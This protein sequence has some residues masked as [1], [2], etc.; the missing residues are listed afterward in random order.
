[1]SATA[2]SFLVL[3]P[4]AAA[5][6]PLARIKKDANGIKLE[7]LQNPVGPFSQGRCDEVLSLTR[8]TEMLHAQQK[9]NC[10]SPEKIT[11]QILMAERYQI[12]FDGARLDCERF[13]QYPREM[14]DTPVTHGLRL[15][16]F[17]HHD[18]VVAELI[19]AA[20]LTPETGTGKEVATILCCNFVE[21][22]RKEA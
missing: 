18:E 11:C 10:F 19:L 7:L 15:K 3:Q 8:A 14:T 1:M 21:W 6:T 16:L 17:D 12:Q 4:Y 13:E 5:E 2:V 22:I 20:K 9:G